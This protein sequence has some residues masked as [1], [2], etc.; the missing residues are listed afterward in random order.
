[1]FSLSNTYSC[2]HISSHRG[3]PRT[4]VHA[5]ARL[6]LNKRSHSKVAV[7][8]EVAEA[9]PLVQQAQEPAQVG[10]DGIMLQGWLQYLHVALEGRQRP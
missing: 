9:E 5:N 8:T 3:C 10:V 2:R 1:M 4:V 6:V 7:A